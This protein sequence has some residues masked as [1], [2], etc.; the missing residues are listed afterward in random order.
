MSQ[1]DENVLYC[2]MLYT[3]ICCPCIMRRKVCLRNVRSTK[4]PSA[5]HPLAKRPVGKTSDSETSD[6]ETSIGGTSAH[7]LFVMRSLIHVFIWLVSNLV[8]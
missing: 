1:D 7:D 4:H 6:G 3:F 2:Y 5:K 8:G